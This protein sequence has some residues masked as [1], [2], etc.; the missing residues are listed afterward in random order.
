MASALTANEATTADNVIEK[1][2]DE[3][4]GDR[5]EPL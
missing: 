2:V 5:A 1:F 4:V 3:F